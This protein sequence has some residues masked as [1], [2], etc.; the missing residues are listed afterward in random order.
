MDFILNVN[1]TKRLI[2]NTD[3]TPPPMTNTN[4]NTNTSINTN[5]Q[6]NINTDRSTPSRLQV[7]RQ[8]R[9]A[10]Q[11]D[12]VNTNTKVNTKHSKCNTKHHINTN[13]TPSASQHR[14]IASTK[15]NAYTSKVPTP[16]TDPK[17][18]EPDIPIN[19]DNDVPLGG[20]PPITKP[21]TLP[22]T[23]ESSHLY[24]E[25]AGITLILLGLILRKR[26]TR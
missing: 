5:D 25:I 9:Q 17:P 16:S 19:T 12:S 21:E 15:C 3:I 14:I 4:T 8:H 22:K 7:Q 13:P 10:T 11:A 2:W 18:A 26:F 1:N 20:L 24:V 23:G 6:V